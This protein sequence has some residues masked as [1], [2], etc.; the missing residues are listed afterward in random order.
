MFY[1]KGTMNGVHYEGKNLSPVELRQ[2]FPEL[3]AI[4][5]GGQVSLRLCRDKITIDRHN[6]VKYPKSISA[7]TTFTAFTKNGESVT[8]GY[9]FSENA[10]KGAGMHPERMPVLL[11]FQPTGPFTS[12][13]EGAFAGANFAAHQYEQFAYFF[14]HPS[15]SANTPFQSNTAPTW[16]WHDEVREETKEIQE[17]Q[18]FSEWMSL[19]RSASDDEIMVRAFGMTVSG[20]SVND[21]ARATVAKVRNEFFTWLGNKV[22]RRAFMESWHDAKQLRLG[23][24]RLAMHRKMIASEHIPADRSVAWKF[25]G[26][27]ALSGQEICRVDSS[28]DPTLG[29]ANWLDSNPG[30]ENALTSAL[31]NVPVAGRSA[32]ETFAAAPANTAFDVEVDSYLAWVNRAVELDM[33]YFDRKASKVFFLDEN[34]VPEDKSIV[35]IEASKAKIWREDFAGKLETATS[36]NTIGHRNRLKTRLSESV[37]N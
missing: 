2:A 4:P 10:P 32:H 36:P 12:R 29:L 3:P 25:L 21:P 13:L 27:G 20:L 11:T 24:V 28:L 18:L 9:Y 30:H 34:G 22:Y 35:V 17:N 33:I 19:V 16:E 8:V 15:F 5:A 7:T 26:V 6:N 14:L 37:Q 31:F 23:K 1:I